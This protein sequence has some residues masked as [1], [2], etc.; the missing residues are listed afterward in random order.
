MNKMIA[1]RLGYSKRFLEAA[2]TAYEKRHGYVLI[3]C[4]SRV[5]NERLRVCTN[6]FCE[7]GFPALYN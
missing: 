1:E 6:F 7:H 2:R 3:N 5:P 4:S